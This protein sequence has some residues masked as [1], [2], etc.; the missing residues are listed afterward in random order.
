MIAVD[1][2]TP[3]K[4]SVLGGTLVTITGYHFG[5]VATDNPVKI[6]DNYCLVESTSE[7][8]IKCRISVDKPTLAGAADV[9]VFAKTSEEMVCNIPTG[10]YFEYEAST[11]TVTSINGFFDGTDYKLNVG[12]TGFDITM[13]PADIANTHL[14]IDGKLQETFSVSPTSAIFKLVDCNGLYT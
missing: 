13:S 9:L 4:G 7:F 12:G 5:S 10:C 6:G 8:E 2:I 1:S 14:Y 11:T 3:S